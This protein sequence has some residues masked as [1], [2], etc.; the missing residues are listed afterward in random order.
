MERDDPLRHLELQKV[1]CTWRMNQAQL[2]VFSNCFSK[3]YTLD[4]EVDSFEDFMA[5]LTGFCS[6]LGVFMVWEPLN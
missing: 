6:S 4:R 2:T 5:P 1:C 3:S